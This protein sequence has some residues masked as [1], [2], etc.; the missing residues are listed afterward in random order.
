MTSAKNK[1]RWILANYNADRKDLFSR[2]GRAYLTKVEL[3]AADRLGV[4]L[5]CEELDQHAAR[6]KTVDRRLKEFAQDAPLPEREARAVLASIPC[7]G[8]VT[9]EVVLAEAPRRP[10]LRLAAE[11]DRLRRL[12]PRHPTER[13][14]DQAAADH[15]S[16]FT[17][18]A[19]DAG[20]AGLAIDE[21]DPS[22]GSVVPAA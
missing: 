10:P 9:T 14:A 16:R 5:L 17:A 22:L 12:G 20:R 18:L 21:Q 11:G 2:A 4:D 19:N 13:Q 1:L 15:Q 7:V 8:A 6:L 3:T